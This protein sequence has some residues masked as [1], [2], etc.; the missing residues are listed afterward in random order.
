MA[1]THL[2]TQTVT[3]SAAASFTFSSISQSYQHLY[4]KGHTSS[5]E[6][7]GTQY[8]YD[9]IE[10]SYNGYT[11]AGYFQYQ[12]TSSIGHNSGTG[13]SGNNEG[14]LA[15]IGGD[16]SYFLC[17]WGDPATDASATQTTPCFGDFDYWLGNYTQSA[18]KMWS[19]SLWE[20]YCVGGSPTAGAMWGRGLGAGNFFVNAAITSVK[21]SLTYGSFNIGSVISMYGLEAS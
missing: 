14:G 17:Q 21:F 3:G 9:T 10:V 18:S 7:R 1:F 13:T 12:D 11:S 2:A 8:A 20:S 19:P 16:N 6:R 5:T 15:F 4:F